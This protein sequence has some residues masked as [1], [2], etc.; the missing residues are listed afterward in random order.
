MVSGKE[1]WTPPPKERSVE[2]AIDHNLVTV[3]SLFDRL[4]NYTKVLATLRAL[5]A[6]EVEI[7]SGKPTSMN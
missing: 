3:M 5:D 2:E 4:Y 1:K 6:A 7:G